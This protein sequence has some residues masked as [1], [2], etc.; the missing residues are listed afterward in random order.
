MFEEV[1]G[2]S[3][4]RT[5]NEQEMLDSIVVGPS[6][7]QVWVHNELKTVR[8]GI[9][10]AKED[11]AHIWE[12]KGYHTVR[13][14]RT[15]AVSKVLLLEVQSPAGDRWMTSDTYIVEVNVTGQQYWT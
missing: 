5:P 11:A 10:D 12:H 15:S 2:S 8:L 9:E 14:R 13:F 6:Q 3:Y 4:D 7:F 1:I